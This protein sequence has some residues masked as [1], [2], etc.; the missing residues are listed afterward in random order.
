MDSRWRI[1]DPDS[2]CFRDWGEETLL[3]HGASGDTHL[4]DILTARVIRGLSRDARSLEVLCD[5]P[6]LWE[7]L[8]PDASRAE[9][10]AFLASLLSE[11]GEVGLVERVAD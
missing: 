5:D 2:L 9:R 11:L 6:S 1:V 8:E 3:F 4:V 7:S 10:R